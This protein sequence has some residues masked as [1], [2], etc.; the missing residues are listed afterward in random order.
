[1]NSGIGDSVALANLGIKTVFHNPSVGQNLTDH[2]IVQQSWFVNETNTWERA[3]RNATVAAEQFELWNTTRTGP[4]TDIPANQVAWLRIPSNSSIFKQFAD[5]AA[6]PQSAHY[7][8][9]FSVSML[10]SYRDILEI[11]LGAHHIIERV[12]WDTTSDREFHDHSL[13]RCLATLS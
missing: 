12:P 6:G 13:R 9:L 2:A 4:L 5:P 8:L 3:A 11:G 10:N 1:M 7:E